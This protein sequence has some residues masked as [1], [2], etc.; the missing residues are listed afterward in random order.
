MPIK[1]SACSWDG[2]PDCALTLGNLYEHQVSQAP[3][4]SSLDVDLHC[5]LKKGFLLKEKTM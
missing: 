5:Y 1:P 3:D 4:K 2:L